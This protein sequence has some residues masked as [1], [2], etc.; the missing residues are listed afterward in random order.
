MLAH[1]LLRGPLILTGMMYYRLCGGSEAGPHRKRLLLLQAEN[2]GNRAA[3]TALDREMVCA[4]SIDPLCWQ[5]LFGAF[6]LLLYTSSVL[7]EICCAGGASQAK[8]P[9]SGGAG[10]S[11]RNHGDGDQQPHAEPG[12]A[13]AW[14]ENYN[15]LTICSWMSSYSAVVQMLDYLMHD[16]VSSGTAFL[17]KWLANTAAVDSAISADVMHHQS[18]FPGL[19]SGVKK[20]LQGDYHTLQEVS[21]Q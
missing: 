11:D 20:A 1:S 9:S 12:N 6:D 18:S 16:L 3:V 8:Q 21:P 13:S 14:Q 17:D 5:T 2:A 4:K 19:V 7:N 10:H 15:F